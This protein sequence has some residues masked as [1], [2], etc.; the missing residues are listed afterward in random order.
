MIG[1]ETKTGVENFTRQLL[2]EHGLYK[3]DIVWSRSKKAIGQAAIKR[4][5][6]TG[7]LRDREIRLSKFWFVD[8][9]ED[10]VARKLRQNPDTDAND[11]VLEDVIRHEIAHALD[12][13][14]RGRSDHGRKWKA[15]CRKTGA[16]PERTTEM[17]LDLQLVAA[18]W[19]RVCDR[20]GLKIPYYSKPG[21]RE[22]SCPD[23][24]EG[25]GFDP[26]A[27]LKIVK[28]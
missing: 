15:K 10:K 5:R 13:E 26:N 20:C 2:D 7:E 23:C 12:Y 25:A 21:G 22:C 24:S 6:L 18:S 1:S 19:L 27:K 4:D 14:D 9:G 17:P 8:M 16:N 3:W 11:D 28:A